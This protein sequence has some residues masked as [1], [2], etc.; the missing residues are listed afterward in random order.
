MGKSRSYLAKDD[1]RKGHL[2]HKAK[3]SPMVDGVEEHKQRE[4][5]KEPKRD[6]KDYRPF[7]GGENY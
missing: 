5:E 4:H 3:H 7:E 6:A 1:R 2:V